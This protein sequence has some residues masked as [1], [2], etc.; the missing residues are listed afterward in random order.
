MFF[1]LNLSSQ[2][3]KTAHFLIGKSFLRLNIIFSLFSLSMQSVI[4]SL[5]FSQ[6]K[7]ASSTRH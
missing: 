4:F 3:L 5:L 7:T 2:L 1:S 6:V